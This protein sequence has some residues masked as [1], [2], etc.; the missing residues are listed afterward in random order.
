VSYSVCGEIEDITKEELFFV[1]VIHDDDDD[2]D[3]Y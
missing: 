1:D 3:E 2:D